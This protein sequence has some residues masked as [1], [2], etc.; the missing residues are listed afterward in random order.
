MLGLS[1]TGMMAMQG[2]GAVLAGVLA[3]ALG[4]TA[5]SAAIAAGERAAAGSEGTG[6]RAAGGGE[7]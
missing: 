6:E 2:V 5:H 3:Q 4:A 1:G 7:A